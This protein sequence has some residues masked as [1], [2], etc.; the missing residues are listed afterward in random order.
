MLIHSHRP[1]LLKELRVV[2]KKDKFWFFTTLN[3]KSRF[4][5]IVYI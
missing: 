4:V 3:L 2:S 1:L 5:D